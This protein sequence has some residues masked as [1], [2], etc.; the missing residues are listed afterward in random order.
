[1]E[2]DE[3]VLEDLGFAYKSY[4]DARALFSALPVVEDETLW[5]FGRSMDDAAI[6]LEGAVRRLVFHVQ[7]Q[8][9]EAGRAPAEVLPTENRY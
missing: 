4:L 7:R 6:R 3:Q 5:R 2:I 9:I 1:M 8:R